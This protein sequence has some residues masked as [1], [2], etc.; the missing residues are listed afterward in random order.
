MAAIWRTALADLARLSAMPVVIDASRV[1]HV[2]GAGIALLVDL[3]RQPRTPEAPVGIEGL[4]PRYQALLA[5]LD[6]QQFAQSGTPRAK[7]E[8]LTIWLGRS[9][10]Q[11]IAALGDSVA[12]LG[13]SA[14]AVVRA[15]LH[16]RSVRWSDALL[17]GQRVGV[18]ALPIISLVAFLIGLILAFQAAVAM[19][20]YGAQ[21]FVANLA[22]ISLLRELGPLITAIVLAGRSGAAFAAEIGTMRV[23]EEV[24][25]LV[26]MGLDPVPFLVVPRILAALVMTPLLTLYADLIGL[27]GG[28]TVMGIFEIPWVAYARQTFAFVTLTDFVSGT[29]KAFVFGLIIAG[30]GCLRGLQTRTGAA[31]VGLSTTSAVVTTIVLIVVTDGIFALLYYALDL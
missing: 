30:V 12:F 7:L 27:I 16:P 23:N 20:P 2:D 6:P 9:T 18:D 21:I 31:A 14:A 5:E 19:R 25:A 11:L 24:D 17:A 28:A 22:G 26:T 15:L 1:E 10:A 29:V 3:L 8:P 4:A 13:E